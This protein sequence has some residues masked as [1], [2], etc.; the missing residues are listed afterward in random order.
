MKAKTDKEVLKA[1]EWMITNIGWCQYRPA[2]YNGDH[3]PMAFCLTGA[4]QFVEASGTIKAAA[5]ELLR[6]ALAIHEPEMHG[7]I[8]GF[9]DSPGRHR[10]EVVKL[11]KRAHRAPKAKK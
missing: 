2:M 5:R 4:I 8:I 6:T 10:D 9:N 1:A 3:V 7:S 11:L